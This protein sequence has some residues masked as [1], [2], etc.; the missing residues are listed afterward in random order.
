[1]FWKLY[2]A[3]EYKVENVCYHSVKLTTHKM[4]AI[5]NIMFVKNF[6]L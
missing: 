4:K 2:S 6:V 3:K 1:M 5:E